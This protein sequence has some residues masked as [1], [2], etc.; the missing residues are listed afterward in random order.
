MGLVEKTVFLSYRRANLAWAR[1]VLKYLTQHGYDV[2]LDFDR[3]GSGAFESVI[4]ENIRLRA[5]FVLLLTPMAL[6]RCEEPDDVL[7]REIITALEMKRNI[8]PLMLEGFDFDTPGTAKQLTGRLAALRNYNALR[9]PGEYFDEAMERL[10]TRY[11]N[12]ALEGV[13]HPEPGIKEDAGSTTSSVLERDSLTDDEWVA[14]GF[15]PANFTA[16]RL[17]YVKAPIVGTFYSRPAPDAP[18]F[19]R[20][21]DLVRAGEPI[22]IVEAMKLM[23]EIECDVTGTVV[24][25]LVRNGEEVEFGMP[26]FAIYPE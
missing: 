18:S 11:L 9:V 16:E 22:C 1:L 26:L 6:E 25:R 19:V 2:F 7:R 15:N 20:V 8:V 13:L 4:V 12:V 21:G 5:H 23:N 10:R 24:A 17:N 3:V 14:R